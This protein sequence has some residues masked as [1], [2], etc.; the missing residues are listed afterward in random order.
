MYQSTLLIATNTVKQIFKNI[1][2]VQSN[3]L[4]TGNR[5]LKKAEVLAYIP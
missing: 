4:G 1:Y 2:Y 5:A 3:I